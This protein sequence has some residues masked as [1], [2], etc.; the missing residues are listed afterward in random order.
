VRIEM[1]KIIETRGT[2]TELCFVSSGNRRMGVGGCRTYASCWHSERVER[3]QDPR[4]A[5][6]S[7]PQTLQLPRLRLRT[8][9]TPLAGSRRG[10]ARGFLSSGR[11][12]AHSP[13]VHRR[14]RQSKSAHRPLREGAVIRLLLL[15]YGPLVTGP[16]YLV[17]V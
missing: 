17:T 2:R 16:D 7:K 11:N 4:Q 10:G 14:F 15:S 8:A 13:A 9:A 12:A 3:F 1:R 5:A 6:G